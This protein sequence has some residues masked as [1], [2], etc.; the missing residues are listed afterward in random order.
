MSTATINSRKLAF[1]FP[2]VGVRLC[3][4]ELAFFERNKAVMEPLL[5]QASSRAGYDLVASLEDE[6]QFADRTELQGQLFTYAFNSA[7]AA[8]YRDH[9]AQPS[10]LAGHSMGIYSALFTAGVVSFSVGLEI[11]AEAYR[12]VTEASEGLDA[13]MAVVVGLGHHEIDDLISELGDDSTVSA[14]NANNDTTAIL[15]GLRPHL[16]EALDRARRRDALK[17]RLLPVAAPYHHLGLLDGA[18]DTFDRFLARQQWSAPSC[19]IVSSIDQTLL[20]SAEALRELTARNISTP[21]SWE[22]VVER[23]IGSGVELIVECGAG[24][25]LQQNGRLMEGCPPFVTVRN[26]SRRAGV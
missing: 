18:S 17:A 3:G 24:I 16:E 14:V 2:G 26:A 4:H 20:D 21:I 7:V 9:G 25:S 8:A 15:A 13:G 19:P 11:V 6:S 5:A 1:A 23:L 22:R 12:V 10:L